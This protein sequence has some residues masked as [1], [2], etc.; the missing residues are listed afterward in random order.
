M[1]MPSDD[2]KD[3]LEQ[4]GLGLTF[5]DNLFV[6]REPSSPNNTTTVFD[7]SGAGPFRTY[8][9]D[10]R[11]H[12]AAIQIR[13]RNASYLQAMTLSQDILFYLDGTANQE[14][15]E[16]YYGIIAALD[17]PFLLDWDENDRARVVTNYEIQRREIG[18]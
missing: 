4:S 1:N 5:T 10:E 8:N 17:H 16:T 9:K 6:G 18:G 3:L 7:T 13:V 14:V 2:I 12:Q 15:N 11:F